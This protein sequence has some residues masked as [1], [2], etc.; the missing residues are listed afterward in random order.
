MYN[1]SWGSAGFVALFFRGALED[2]WWGLIYVVPAIACRSGAGGHAPLGDSG[3][4]DQ[5][6]ARARRGRGGART[7]RAGHAQRTA[8][9]L[10]M[11]W[12]GN[13]LAYTGINVLLPVLLTLAME[14]GFS[15]S[16]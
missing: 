3:N 12:L 11:A 4:P 10:K 1:L 5:Q 2:L 7:G 15:A 16:R 13:A 9:L 8:S 14:A 6:G